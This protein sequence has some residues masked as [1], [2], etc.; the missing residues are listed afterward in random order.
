M[1]IKI[2]KPIVFL[3]LLFHASFINLPYINGYGIYKYVILL[4]VGAF[5]LIKFQTFRKHEYKN[6]S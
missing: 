1:N 5:L 2:Y 6:V 4:I 3:I